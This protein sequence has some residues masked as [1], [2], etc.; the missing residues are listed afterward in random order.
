MFKLILTLVTFPA[1]FAYEGEIKFNEKKPPLKNCIN[2]IQ[3]VVK[4]AA[5]LEAIQDVWNPEI[6]I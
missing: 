3:V 1:I 5:V 6:V 4:H 2:V